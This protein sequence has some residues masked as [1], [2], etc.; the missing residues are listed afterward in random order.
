MLA[1][2]LRISNLMLKE[3]AAG[4]DAGLYMNAGLATGAVQLGAVAVAAGPGFRG[5]F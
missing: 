1:D 2:G 5:Q 4:L 3:Y